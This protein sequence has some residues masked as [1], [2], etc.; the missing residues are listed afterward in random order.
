MRD[1]TL[2]ANITKSTIDQFERKYGHEDKYEL[3]IRQMA[4][5]ELGTITQD[6]ITQIAEY[7]LYSWGRMGRVLG[8]E[9]YG[10]WQGKVACFIVQFQD[11]LGFFRLLPLLGEDLRRYETDIKI[12]Y[13]A[14]KS[15]VGPI[16]AVKVLHLV[17]PS[18][19]PLWDNAI[20]NGLRQYYYGDSTYD[21]FSDQDYFDFMMWVQNWLREND[22]LISSL[23][24]QYDKAKLKMIDEFFWWTVTR[25][26]SLVV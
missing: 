7:Y 4:A 15:A 9:E 22:N 18:F 19:F 1:P 13:Q 12:I 3:P 17:C 24:E 2:A 26:F 8:R 23:S 6:D 20:A 14:L 10:G 5:K 21:S 16:G 11:K 25:P